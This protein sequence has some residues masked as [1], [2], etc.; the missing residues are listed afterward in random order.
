MVLDI[1]LVFYYDH[2][3]LLQIKHHETTH[4]LPHRSD[5]SAPS[6]T[7]LKLMCGLAGLLLGN[8]ENSVSKLIQIVAKPCSL[9][10][11]D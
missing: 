8:S 1:A 7:R 11:Q 9:W 6:F 3:R 10:L 5:W 4:L 2:N